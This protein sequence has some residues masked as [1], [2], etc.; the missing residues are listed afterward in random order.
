MINGGYQLVGTVFV[1][2]D[3]LLPFQLSD[4]MQFEKASSEQIAE[5]K[6]LAPAFG[7]DLDPFESMWRREATDNPASF[8]LFKDPLPADRLRYLVLNFRGNNFLPYRF[9]KFASILEPV[10]KFLFIAHTDQEFGAGNVIGWGG[11]VRY[12]RPFFQEHEWEVHPLSKEDLNSVK[13]NWEMFNRN[14][15]E[16]PFLEKV[17]DMIYDLQNIPNHHDLYF[18]GLFSILELML[19]HNPQDRE[20]ADSLNHQISTKIPLL[21]DRMS[22]KPDYSIFANGPSES[23]FWKL[24]Y[25]ARSKIAHGAP[26]NFLSGELQPLKSRELALNFLD[27]I[28]RRIALQAINEPALFERL[29]PI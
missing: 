16:Y 11:L 25:N 29:K 7:I 8:Q 17:V 28:T 23:K 10:T 9:M 19:T 2:E 14:V 3:G 27:Q 4:E 6:R 1:P 13:S 26:L 24:L 20:N 12:V 21:S 15:G 22:K 5:L 18:L